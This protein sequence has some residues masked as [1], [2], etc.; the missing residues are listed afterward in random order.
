VQ[1]GD[2]G[3]MVLGYTIV[4]VV[5]GGLAPTAFLAELFP[6]R[7]RYSGL[8]LTYG[9]ASAVFGGTTPLVA[10]ALAQRTAAPHLP[11]WYATAASAIAFV[12]V[13]SA[14]E[15]ADQALDADPRGLSTGSPP[16][17]R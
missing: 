8:S 7:L 4:G 5:L 14:P 2:M 13:L 11:A 9:I 17:P 6:T 15:T 1:A 12:C 10:A 3:R 16:T